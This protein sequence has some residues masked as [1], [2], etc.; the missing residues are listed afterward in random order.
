MGLNGVSRADPDQAVGV[1]CLTLIKTVPIVMDQRTASAC[2]I[3]LF[4]NGDPETC[5]GESRGR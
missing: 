4:N 1:S 3:V 2:E 5:L